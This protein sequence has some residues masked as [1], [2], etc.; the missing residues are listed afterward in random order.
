M[1]LL[2][3]VHLDLSLNALEWNRDLTLPISEIRANESG[4]TDLKGRGTNTVCL[5]EMRK[6]GIG[7]CVAT[8]IGG[9]MKP[10]ASVACWES[11]AQAWGMTQGQLAYYQALCDLGEM[12]QITTL[13]QL[14]AHLALWADPVAAAAAKAPIGF[15][16]SLE[17]ADSIVSLDYLEKAYA[18]GL[19]ALGPAHYG[20][21]R[22]ALGHDQVGGLL[23][24][25]AELIRKMDELGIILDVTHLSDA[26]FFEALDI[27]QGT[28]WASHSNCRTLVDDPRQFSDKQIRLLIERGAVLG[29]V[30]DAWMMVPGWIRGT[31]TPESTGVVI[32]HI[33][34][35]IDHICQLAGNANHVGIGSDLDGGFG[36]EQ[37]PGDLNTIA[38]L[39]RIE[40]I[41]K[42]RGYS[43]ADITGLFHGN[44][45]RLLRE[46]W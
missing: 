24:G 9:C 25:G 39:Q 37:S 27:Y 20:R 29:A 36:R 7:L 22:Y 8:Q 6:G 41:L 28:V 16:L 42:N 31:S 46:A 5:D 23:P 11:P 14:D 19:R 13:A 1:N 43:D 35:H 33:A 2:F 30:F 44:F 15:V 12:V 4:R 45:L 38:D 26:C 32:A 3:D 18:S 17:G 21:G 40:T 10:S 34:D